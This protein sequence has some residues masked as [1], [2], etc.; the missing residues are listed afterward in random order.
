MVE[1]NPSTTD[2]APS[3]LATAPMGV[4]GES[5]DISVAVLKDEGAIRDGITLDT[6]KASTVVPSVVELKTDP[7]PMLMDDKKEEPLLQ[8]K[9]NMGLSGIGSD[10][11]AAKIG[12]ASCRER[13]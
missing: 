11:G 13:V 2:I 9:E 7:C 12:R 1:P 3:S 6:G 4:A 8:T 10:L 5:G